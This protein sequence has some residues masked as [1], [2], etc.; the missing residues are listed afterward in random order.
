LNLA[1]FPPLHACDADGQK[2][3]KLTLRHTELGSQ[4]ADPPAG[5]QTVTLAVSIC[6]SKGELSRVLARYSFECTFWTDQ[7]LHSNR[8]RFALTGTYKVGQLLLEVGVI[9]FWTS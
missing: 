3:R 8:V 5:E 7:S 4:I 2:I 6:R 1:Y 9:T